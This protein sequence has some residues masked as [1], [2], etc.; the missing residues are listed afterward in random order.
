ML[1]KYIIVFSFLFLSILIVLLLVI[2]YFY[3]IS[4]EYVKISKLLDKEQQLNKK[5]LNDINAYEPQNF[6]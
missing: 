4:V 5:L 1:T 6:V 3:I 2:R